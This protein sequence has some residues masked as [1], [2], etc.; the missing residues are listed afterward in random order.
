MATI[1][2]VNLGPVLTGLSENKVTSQQNSADISAALASL[3][4]K[5]ELESNQNESL[6]NDM[7]SL[8]ADLTAV[9]NTARDEVMAAPAQSAIKSI[10]RGV[11][12]QL[13]SGNSSINI[14]I[15]SVNMSKSVLNMVVVADGSD[16]FDSVLYSLDAANRINVATEYGVNQ[17]FKGRWQVIEYV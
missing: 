4:G 12:A 13:I 15:S 1:N 9:V 8:K 7:V 11:F 10:Q 5:I 17:V 6:L 14:G 2:A 3:L 16:S